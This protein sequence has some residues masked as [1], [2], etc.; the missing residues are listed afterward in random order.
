[1]VRSL[2]TLGSARWVLIE[3]TSNRPRALESP[4]ALLN[5]PSTEPTSSPADLP[6]M[7]QAAHDYIQS[8]RAGRTEV[9]ICSDLRANDWDAQTVRWQS[10]RDAFLQFPQ[11]V[12]FHLLAYSQPAPSNLAVRVTNVRWQKTSDGAELLVSL[13]LSA[14][15]ASEAQRSIPIE[16]EIDGARSLLNVEMSGATFDVKDQRIPLGRGRQQG[17]GRVSIPADSNPADNDFY[18]AFGQPAPR[19][20]IIVADD[21]QAVRPLQLAASIAPLAGLQSSAEVLSVDQ[22]P[23]VEWERVALLVWQSALPDGETA[24]QIDDFVARGGQVIFLPPRVPDDTSFAGVRWLAWNES[25]AD[26]AVDSWRGDQDLLAHTASGAALPVGQ[27][28]IRNYC[29]LEGEMI[30]LA[31]L[32]GGDA[33]LARVATNQGGVYF[34]ATTANPGDSTLASDGIVLYVLVQ[35]A[36]AGGAAVLENT[37]QLDAGANLAVDLQW[38]RVSGTEGTLSTDYAFHRG[39]YE[40]GEKLFA[41]NVPA[42]EELAPVLPDSRVAGLFRG[43]DFS[44]VDDR[45]GSFDALVQEIWRLFLVSMMLA[46]LIEAGLCLPKLKRASGASR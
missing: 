7:L 5:L 28:Q 31:A 1:L 24:R 19:E 4:E 33:L 45:A 44:R 36:L 27:L 37:Q 17:W 25:T 21:A 16:F 23:A 13:R 8:N 30:P 15:G 38:K 41:V 46:L 10:L 11:G 35:R 29:G 42:E 26:S 20:T 14:E 18:F 3:S 12:R 40:N 39:V 34:L 43:L 6:A 9:W 22:L 2:K 32:R